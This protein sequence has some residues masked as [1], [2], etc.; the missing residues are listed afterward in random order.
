MDREIKKLKDFKNWL[1][2]FIKR[3]YGEKCPDFVW[4]CPVCHAY[5]V[6]ELFDDFVNDLIETE[7]WSK[8]KETREKPKKIRKKIDYEK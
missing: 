5:F 2:K 6:K 7:N 8:S 3:G 1:D 4:G